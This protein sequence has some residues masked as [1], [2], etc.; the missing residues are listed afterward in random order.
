MKLNELKPPKNSRHSKKRV[1]RG[2]GSGLGK[3]CGRGHKGQKS[4][5]G[6]SIPAWFE[7]G[8]MPLVRRI[9]K[10]GPRRTGHVRI[11]YS[12][13]NIQTLNTFEDGATVSLKTMFE[14]GIVKGKNSK[15][16]ILGDGEIEKKL[17]VQA[18]KFSKTAVEKIEAVGGT[19]EEI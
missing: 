10:S 9:P 11:E 15:V 13:V 17:T 2:H 12:V 6:V 16:K 19:A 5:S 14:S 3:T 7:G 4:R 18:H 1:G 8:Q